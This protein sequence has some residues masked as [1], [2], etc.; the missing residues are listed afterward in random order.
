MHH[1]SINHSN[2]KFERFK[3]PRKGWSEAF[4]EMHAAGDDQLYIDDVFE[5]EN[6]DE[7][8]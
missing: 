2:R 3:E 1:G 8:N 4:A 5:D 7:W 6:F